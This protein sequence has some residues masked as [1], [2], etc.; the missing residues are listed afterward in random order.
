MVKLPKPIDYQ[1]YDRQRAVE[2]AVTAL[3]EYLSVW[4]HREEQH[5]AHWT[6]SAPKGLLIDVELGIEDKIAEIW[7][8]AAKERGLAWKADELGRRY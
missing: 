6:V 3:A 4:G 5:H 8:E 7:D 2:D 1:P